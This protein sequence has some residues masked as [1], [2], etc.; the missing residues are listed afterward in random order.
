MI[1]LPRSSDGLKERELR[2]E[3]EMTHTAA[4]RKLTRRPCGTRLLAQQCTVKKGVGDS[5]SRST[6]STVPY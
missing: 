1:I 4:L 3:G 5:R 2:G 6:L